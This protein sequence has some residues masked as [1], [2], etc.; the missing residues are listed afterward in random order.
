MVLRS[1]VL[2]A[3]L[4]FPVQIA[5]PQASTPVAVETIASDGLHLRGDFYLLG[6]SQPTIL[7]LHEMY[8]DH[9]SWNSVIPALTDAGY[10]VLAVDL[11]GYGVTGG[12][13]NWPLAITD[14]QVWFDWLRFDARVR[15]NRI[16]IMGSSMGANLALIGCANASACQTAVAISPGWEYYGIYV[17]EAVRSGRPALIVFSTQDRWP[18][19]GVPLMRQ[20][21]PDTL[22]FQ[23]YPGNQHGI[24]LFTTQG[25]TLIPLIVAWFAQHNG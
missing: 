1:I 24:G 17:D 12:T 20:T 22:V 18:A 25:E 23:E 2:F 6:Q 15:E 19:E 10:N 7:L 5:A 21:A 4:I 13:I 8:T 16:S 14:V 3:L 11:R 9:S